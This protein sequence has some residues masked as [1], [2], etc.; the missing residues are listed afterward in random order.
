MQPP[1]VSPLCIQIRSLTVRYRDF[2][3]LRSLS[4]EFEPGS[5]AAVL[6]P[7]GAGKSTLA[8]ALTRL[9]RAAEGEIRYGDRSLERISHAELARQVAVVPQD[10]WVPFDYTVLEMVL[11]GRA[12]HLG[13]LGLE[14]ERDVSLA[15]A[16][17]ER[18]GLL[19]LQQRSF[20]TLSG[21]ERQRV[22]L[23]RALAQDAPVLLLDEP[24]A[25]QDIGHQRGTLDLLAALNREGRTVL[26]V[27]HD[28]NLAS[29]YFPRLV[30]LAAG[31]VAADG[32]A[33]TV[34]TE[35]RLR[36]VYGAEVVVAPHPQ[37]GRPVVLPAAPA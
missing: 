28:L 3:A 4:L 15:R 32:T 2:T 36:E 27:L 24:T 35:E 11:M 22:L 8:R 37:N 5:M 34:L 23:A 29:L 13:A 7:N 25:H 21:G 31:E 14:G 9:V 19:P 26:A 12:P 33:E 17:L 16:S 1:N 10:V 20:Q 6:G 18:L 30:L